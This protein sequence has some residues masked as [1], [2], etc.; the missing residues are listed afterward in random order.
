MD[1]RIM[2][3]GG[4]LIPTIHEMAAD[5]VAKRAG[6][7][8]DEEACGKLLKLLPAALGDESFSEVVRTLWLA[9]G[10]SQIITGE[11][12]DDLW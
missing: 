11:P 2:S 1:I 9:G 6:I 10:A 4:Q 12:P 7:R 8:D 5:V 3:R